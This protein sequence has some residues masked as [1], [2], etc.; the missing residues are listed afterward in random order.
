MRLELKFGKYSIEYTYRTRS[1]GV[2]VKARSSMYAMRF[3]FST[4]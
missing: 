4:L 1:A 2:F 3:R